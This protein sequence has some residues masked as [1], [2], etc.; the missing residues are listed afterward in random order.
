MGNDIGP[1]GPRATGG[2][3]GEPAHPMNQAAETPAHA[4]TPRANH[5][6]LLAKL[7]GPV[8][9]M[10]GAMRDFRASSSADDARAAELRAKTLDHARK[11]WHACT[12]DNGNYAQILDSIARSITFDGLFDEP[13]PLGHVS[14][15]APKRVAEHPARQAVDPSN[16][17]ELRTVFSDM[18]ALS[19]SLPAHSQR[20]WVAALVR[21]AGMLP[22]SQGEQSEQRQ[23]LSAARQAWDRRKIRAADYAGILSMLGRGASSAHPKVDPELLDDISMESLKLPV[24]FRAALAR[25]LEQAAIAPEQE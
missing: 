22:Y 23:A 7:V 14:G 17:E 1:T 10:A 8:R 18:L 19:S 11:S 15:G 24:P 25:S 6:A 20:H 21:I 4:A 2:S 16:V 9:R 3:D 5:S 13:P 12:M